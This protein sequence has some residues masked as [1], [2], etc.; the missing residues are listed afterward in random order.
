[1]RLFSFFKIIFVRPMF[2]QS[3]G[4]TFAQ[5]A[6]MAELLC[7]ALDERSDP[8]TD[9]AVANNFVGKIDAQSTH[10]R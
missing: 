10:L 7:M 3:T 5:F 6:A 1:M 4:P 2:S 8:S 9:V